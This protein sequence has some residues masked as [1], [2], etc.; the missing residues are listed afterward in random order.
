MPE[1]I[2]SEIGGRAA[3]LARRRAL[4]VGKAALPPSTDR[5]SGGR[6][7]ADA[8]P[9]TVEP[10]TSYEP[11]PMKVVEPLFAASTSVHDQAR[12]RRAALSRVGRG[13]APPAA[14]TRQPRP[15]VIDV[16]PIFGEEPSPGVRGVTGM[17][18]AAGSTVTGSSRGSTLPVS[19]TQSIAAQSGAVWRAAGPKVGLM[20]TAGGLVVSGTLVR[21]SVR[22]T[23][24]EP[25]GGIAITGEADQV[26]GDDLTPRSGEGAITTGR[27]APSFGTNFGRGLGSGGS[28]ERDGLRRIES[29]QGGLPLTGSSIGRS[30]RVTGDEAG[31]C[32]QVT[33]DQ[34]LSPANLQAECGGRRGGTAPAALVGSGR[35][36]PASGAKVSAALTRGFQ[37]VTGTGLEP[38]ARVT[39]AGSSA[40]DAVTGSQYEGAVAGKAA[41]VRRNASGFVTGGIAREALGV[42]GAERGAARDISGTPYSVAAQSA[43]ALPSDPVAAIAERFSVNS[44]QRSAHLRASSEEST[45]AGDE[46]IT[47]SFA[48]GHDKVTGNL[49]FSFRPR[50]SAEGEV[51]APRSSITG[52]GSKAG[53]AITGDGALEHPKVTGTETSIASQRN[54]SERGNAPKPFAGAA[55]FKAL[56]HYEEPKHLVTGMFGYSSDSGAK[57]TLSG[58][59]QG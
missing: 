31:V 42:T 26:P 2:G 8:A 49:E 28:R 6:R 34:Y 18:E 47:G 44:P 52:E 4:S 7:E 43:S 56:A 20:R 33:G 21:S 58:G 59:A 36:D 3:S 38:D 54:P 14:P 22:V 29:T 17:R 23:G 5:I 46:R 50:R 12:A 25:G 37:R 32:R 40:N 24:D 39:G 1:P 35:P 10:V 30:I 9:I 55:R 16:Q 41:P 45:P 57:V 51:R 11:T 48:A 53:T 15:V 13:D 19:G 27:F